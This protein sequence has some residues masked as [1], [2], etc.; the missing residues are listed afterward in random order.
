MP[1]FVSIARQTD[2]PCRHFGPRDRVGTEIAPCPKIRDHVRRLSSRQS[3]VA[4]QGVPKIIRQRFVIISA[5][6]CF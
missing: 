2:T 4:T 3:K 1:V 5:V 6:T